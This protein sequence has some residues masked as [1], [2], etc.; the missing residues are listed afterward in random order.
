MQTLLNRPLV[1][2][3]V[4]FVIL[5]AATRLGTRLQIWRAPLDATRKG[6]FDIVLGATLTLLSLIVGF[7]FS[8]ASSRY[9]QRKNYEEDEANAI[10]TAYARADLL[11]SADAVKIKQLLREYTDLRIRA[12]TTVDTG[13]VP[14]LTRA[15][16]Q[17]QQQLWN[18]VVA[19]AP[20]SPTVLTGL[21]TAAMNDALNAQGYAQAAAWNR[22]PAGAWALMY[23]LGAVAAAM[24]GYRFQLQSREYVLMLIMPGIVALAFFLIADIDCPARGVIR[25]L[26]QNLI[27]LSAALR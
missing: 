24:I 3:V 9:D 17:I 18:S 2:W 8:M 19:A 15:T 13:R 11:P 7:S 20:P 26:P 5:W 25:I 4:S 21:A 22:I 16:S 1:L 6:D 23:V 10:G 14:D 27:A 12:Y